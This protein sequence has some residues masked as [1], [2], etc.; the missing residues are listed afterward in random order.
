[1]PQGGAKYAT[2][3]GQSAALVAALGLVGWL[4]TRTLAGPTSIASM[5]AGCGISLA[6]A[7]IAGWLVVAA[8]VESPN[9]R[10]Q[11]AMLAMAVRVVVVLVL[12]VAAALSAEFQRA[13]LLVWLA[14]AYVG[15]LPLE[16]KLTLGG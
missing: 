16:V 12:G 3:A 9:A 7:L 14:I 6:A 2:F 11:R 8:P 13:P 4:P 5:A 10:M 1:V 15:L